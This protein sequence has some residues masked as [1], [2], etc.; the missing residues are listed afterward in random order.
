MENED[1][2]GRHE[3]ETAGGKPVELLRGLHVSKRTLWMVAGGAVAALAGLGLER[4]FSL[5]RPAV[6]GVLK[7]GYGFK[8][9]LA[10]RF[11]RAKEDIQDVVAEAAYRHHRDLTATAEAVKREKE[12]LEKVEKLVDARLERTPAGKKEEQP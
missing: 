12:L 7:E 10:G 8:E 2:G 6:V 9:W 3:P 4:A 1:R 5:T 11:E